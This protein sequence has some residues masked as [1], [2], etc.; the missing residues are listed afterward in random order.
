V[1]PFKSKQ[2]DR[3][4]ATINQIHDHMIPQQQFDA[5]LAPLITGIGTLI[6]AVDALIA[7][8]PAADLTAED[9]Q[10]LAAAAT[11][12]AEINKLNPPKPVPT[13]TPAPT[14]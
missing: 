1:W 11:V 4:E 5:D 7:S 6:T 3:I 10:V 14:P 8:K 12:S 2:L 13:P 9:Q